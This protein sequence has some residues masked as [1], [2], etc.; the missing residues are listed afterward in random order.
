LKIFIYMILV[1]GGTGFIGSLL[2]K[3][4]LG[5]GHDVTVLALPGQEA[6]GGAKVVR[7]DITRGE[8][9]KGL[10]GMETVVHLAGMVSYSESREAL[11]RVNAQGTRNV[12]GACR[13]AGRFILS[14]SV[15][16][17]G[18]IK[19]TAGE[20]YPVNP[21]NPYG[22]S[23][24]EAEKAVREAGIPSVVFRIAPVYGK[25]SP[26]WLKNLRLLEKGFPIPRTR[27]LTHVVHISDIVQALALAVRKGRGVYN[28]ADSKPVRFMEFAEGLMEL[29]GKKPRRLP[30]WLVRLLARARGMGAY[31][32]VLTIN[33]NYSI[34]KAGREL[35]YRPRANLKAEMKR[36]VD[37]YL[38]NRPIA[39]G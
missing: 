30:L 9:L 24:L 3:R 32:D 35:G 22:E 4:L 8:T 10:G 28:I 33:R 2:V 6:P 15:S 26:S 23:K 18:E 34:E 5:D 14:S 20:D 17:Y 1:T 39:T 7:G 21:M 37:W 11:L 36:M 29:L 31:L 13:G 27:N 16:V 25:G 19:G 38:E 12:L